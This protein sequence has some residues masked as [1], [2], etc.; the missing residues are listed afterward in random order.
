MP[1][2]AEDLAALGNLRASLI[3]LACKIFAPRYETCGTNP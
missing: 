2:F 3:A 1:N